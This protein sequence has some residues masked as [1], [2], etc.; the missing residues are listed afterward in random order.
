M[1]FRELV[2]KNIEENDAVTVGMETGMSTRI[3]YRMIHDQQWIHFDYADR[4]VCKLAGP[5]LWQEEP[6]KTLYYS[7]DLSGLDRLGKVT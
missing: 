7:T 5:F 4:I 2:M 1:P 6:F 3:I